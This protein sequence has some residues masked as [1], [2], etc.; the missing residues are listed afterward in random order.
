M[1]IDLNLIQIFNGSLT[2]IHNRVFRYMEILII[3]I[4]F[5]NT[6]ISAFNK[7]SFALSG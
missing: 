4:I 7:I 1:K 6:F 3:S 2:I 5:L